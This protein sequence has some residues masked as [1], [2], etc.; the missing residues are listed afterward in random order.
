MKMS[1]GKLWG[2]R[3]L[4]DAAGLWKMVAID[5]RTPLFVPMAKARGTKDA[6]YED[7]ARFKAML[8]RHLAPRGSALLVD[9]NFGYAAA[10]PEMPANCGLML[11][12]EH[13]VTEETPGGR[14]SSSI[15]DWSVEKIRKIGGDAVK[16]LIWH[17]ADSAPEVR[18]HQI[19]YAEAVGRHCKEHD[20]VYLLEILVYPLPGEDAVAS[21]EVRAERVLAAAADFADP[22][23]QVDIYKMEPP[24]PLSGVADPDGKEAAALQKL[25][26]KLGAM[27]PKPWVLLSAGAS[28]EDFRRALVYGYRAGASGYLCGRAIWHNAFAAFP[29]FDRIETLLKTESIAY[30]DRINELTDRAA[31]PWHKHA[32]FGGMPAPE[33]TGPLFAARYP[34]D[35]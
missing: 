32:A 15:P 22:R 21:P 2:M 35:G 20:I 1:A 33:P 24:S 26:D 7:V 25:Y 8:A 6:A 17:R 11:S 12:L 9:P 10:V 5:Q 4:A 34:T 3:R 30:I 13:H 19:A 27:L 23:L 31:L 14:K 28:A 29:D 16:L 18:A